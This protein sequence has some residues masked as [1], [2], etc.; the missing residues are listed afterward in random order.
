IELTG[1]P[2]G[3]GISGQDP[4]AQNVTVPTDADGYVFAWHLWGWAGLELAALTLGGVGAAHY[5]STPVS[6]AG[7]DGC[8]VA[9]G[10]GGSNT[11]AQPL[12]GEYEYEDAAIGSGPSAGVVWL[13]GLDLDAPVR[14]S[15]SQVFPDGGPCSI[16][17]ATEP[18]DIVVGM[19]GVIGT[20]HE[21]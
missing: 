5:E 14:S 9:F 12:D 13:K 10:V 16:E 6:P 7:D 2:T 18:G 20:E 1:N 17:L 19:L 21:G 3:F 4:P 11:G 15:E 8:G